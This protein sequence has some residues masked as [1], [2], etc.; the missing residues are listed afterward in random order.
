[1]PSMS[2]PRNL[3]RPE[4]EN[5]G[6]MFGCHIA[7]RT[8]GGYMGVPT[9]DIYIVFK[10]TEEKVGNVPTNNPIYLHWSAQQWSQTFQRISGRSS[11]NLWDQA[12]RAW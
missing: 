6:K 11:A 7:T 1:M 12:R 2:K 9:Y 10:D 3:S 4:I 5:L 8:K